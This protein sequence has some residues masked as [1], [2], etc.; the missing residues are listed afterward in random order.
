MEKPLKPAP[1]QSAPSFGSEAPALGTEPSR[2]QPKRR[3]KQRYTATNPDPALEPEP[4]SIDEIL[5][6][7][8]FA[9]ADEKDG[10]PDSGQSL[11]DVMRTL[12]K[13]LDKFFVDADV[14]NFRQFTSTINVE[15]DTRESLLN[16]CVV[17]ATKDAVL[18]RFLAGNEKTSIPALVLTRDLA[19]LLARKLLQ[20]AEISAINDDERW[21][22]I[23]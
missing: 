14:R 5:A 16:D 23:S 2:P 15:V 6:A 21:W 9:D 4:T 7:F 11:I 10:E 8:A 22:V 17:A 12:D 18:I 20:G 1:K 13:E 3:P 19:I